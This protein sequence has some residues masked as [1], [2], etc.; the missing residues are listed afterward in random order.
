MEVALLAPIN[1]SRPSG[2]VVRVLELAFHLQ[3][4]GNDVYLVVPSGSREHIKGVVD[5]VLEIPT[6]QFSNKYARYVDNL[7]QMLR[8]A[9]EL[10]SLHKFDIV[11][12]EMGFT[13]PTTALDRRLAS[14]PFVADMHSIAAFD[15]LDTFPAALGSITSRI[16]WRWQ[17][18]LIK[19]SRISIGVSNAMQEVLAASLPDYA[20]KLA[21]IP[22]GVNLEAVD[23]SVR[24]FKRAFS[25]T[26]EMGSFV[27]MY[28]GSLETYEGVD[29]L[30]RSIKEARNRGLDAA[31]VVAGAGTKRQMLQQLAVDLGLS[32]WIRFVDWIPYHQVFGLQANADVLVAP[33]RPMRVSD[34]SFPLKVPN[35][36]AVGKPV[37]SSSVGDIPKVLRHNI[38]GLLV[39]PCD[40]VSL[41]DALMLL[42]ED[43][44]LR[45]KLAQNAKKRAMAFDWKTLV[46]SLRKI[47][48]MV[49][50]QNTASKR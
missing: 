7:L 47:Y 49:I 41:A 38:D 50:H 31:A 13:V 25:S 9:P 43:P 15:F 26:R 30:I 32:R 6:S 5:S 16:A 44:A 33:R 46:E 8:K 11:Q 19:K 45:Q 18:R 34:I 10:L 3:R 2:D 40:P 48:E 39:R 42:A 1:F 14:L 29:I 37:V 12:G 24:K 23:K 4:Q 20:Y 22:N 36:F 28:V 17:C 21:T 27:V 35:Y